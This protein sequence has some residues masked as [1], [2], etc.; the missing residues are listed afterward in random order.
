LN[1]I[2]IREFE[3]SW[4]FKTNQINA[5]VP[6]RILHGEED[7]NVPVQHSQFICKNLKKVDTVDCKFVPDVA[8]ELCF[9]DWAEHLAW[10]KKHE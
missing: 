1:E 3:K 5:V 4:G 10:M 6:T 7:E 8:H 2:L 9:D